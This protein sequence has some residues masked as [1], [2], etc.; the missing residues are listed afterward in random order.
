MCIGCHEMKPKRELIRIVRPPEGEVFVD[1]SGKKSGRGAYVCPNQDCLNKAFKSKAMEK[2]LQ[3]SVNP[4]TISKLRE[5][6]ENG[7]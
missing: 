2:A 6:V 7:Q 3:V 5:Q 1:F 4:E